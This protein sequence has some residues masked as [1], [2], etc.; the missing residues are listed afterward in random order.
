MEPTLVSTSPHPTLPGLALLLGLFHSSN[1]HLGQRVVRHLYNRDQLNLAAVCH[2]LRDQVSW[3]NQTF[4][5]HLARGDW[6]GKIGHRLRLIR[7]FRLRALTSMPI[8]TDLIQLIIAPLTGLKRLELNIAHANNEL[9]QFLVRDFAY[10]SHLALLG[11]PWNFTSLLGTSLSPTFHHLVS[12]TLGCGRSQLIIDDLGDILATDYPYLRHLSLCFTAI[13]GLYPE[14]PAEWHSLLSLLDQPWPQITDLRLRQCSL[15]NKVYQLIAN[16]F[17]NIQEVTFSRCY[18][19]QSVPKI[20]LSAF[21]QLH[22][23]YINSNPV[24]TDQ[25]IFRNL[26]S[27]TVA[28]VFMVNIGLDWEHLQLLVGRFPNLQELQVELTS[29]DLLP[30]FKD[31]YPFIQIRD[32]GH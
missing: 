32:L 12:L 28:F 9:P 27:D 13:V 31:T 4:R 21:P 30:L 24:A 5:E 15:G 19:V 22:C 14:S 17:R 16:N 10:V 1:P 11:T 3:S 20:S 2:R 29:I 8:E 23:L 6:P 18:T 26:Y 25:Y 7:G